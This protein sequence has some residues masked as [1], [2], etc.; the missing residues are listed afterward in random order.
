MLIPSGLPSTCSDT[1][2]PHGPW[3]PGKGAGA[4]AFTTATIVASL[5]AFVVSS[6]KIDRRAL[7]R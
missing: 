4:R 2:S 5:N 6:V 1:A 3:T 7:C